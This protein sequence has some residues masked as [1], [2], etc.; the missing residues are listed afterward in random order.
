MQWERRSGHKGLL[1]INATEK[2][3]KHPIPKHMKI[4]DIRTNKNK[5]NKADINN[6][7]NCNSKKQTSAQ[8]NVS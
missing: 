4:P 6:K 7:E 1:D 5:C 2:C 3:R 8:H